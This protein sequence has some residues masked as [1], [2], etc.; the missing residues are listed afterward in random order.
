[1]SESV[2][3]ATQGSGDSV[4]LDGFTRASEGERQYRRPACLKPEQVG[5]GEAPGLGAGV[6]WLTSPSVQ[7]TIGMLL[8]SGDPCFKT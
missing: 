5:H 2:L 3:P 1:M 4:R 6:A 8:L 7:V